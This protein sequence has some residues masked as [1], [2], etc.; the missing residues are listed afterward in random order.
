LIIQTGPEKA[1]LFIAH[2]FGSTCDI[3][4]YTLYATLISPLQ[5]YYFSNYISYNEEKLYLASNT[6]AKNWIVIRFSAATQQVT[7]ATDLYQSGAKSAGDL[8]FVN[9][10][11]Y[12]AYLRNK[13]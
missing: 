8:V 10:A 6:I 7:M 5:D 13:D 12:I 11:S 3:N 9:G 1:G 2:F 4:P